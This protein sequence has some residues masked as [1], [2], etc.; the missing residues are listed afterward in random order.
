MSLV[1]TRPEPALSPIERDP[2]WR[3]VAARDAAADGQF[4]Y[5]VRTTGVYCRPTCPSRRA[6]PENVA[7]F[8][9]GLA[10]ALEGF[11]PCLRC[12]PDTQSPAQRHAAIVAAACEQI[13]KAEDL[14]DLHSLA[15]SAGLSPFHFHRVFK[16]TT[17][18]TPK[19]YGAAL[20]ARRVRKGLSSGEGS[21]TEAVY[22][23]GFNASSRF[24]ATTDAVLGMSP[25]AFRRGGADATVRFAV[26]QSS[27][28]AVLVART[29]KGVCA[30][31]LGDDPDGLVRELQ[32][33]FSKAELVGGDAQ[34]EDLVARVVGLVEQPALGLDLPLDVRGTA[35]QQRVWQALRQ[36]PPGETVSYA[37][38]AKRIGAPKAVRAV[39]T[40][41]G[42]NIL[43]VA[44]PC[45]R[46]IRQDGMGSGYRWGVERK[47]ALI[48]R[49]AQAREASQLA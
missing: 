37:E 31:L 42:S 47:R 38:I 4:V 7:F 36:I 17:G 33:R 43:A 2:R 39:G 27:L 6:K 34:F 24:Y 3:A 18:L 49:E 5:G 19:A 15:E 28:G 12:R 45:H 10:A 11:R 41:C 40:A 35:F 48:A 1:M 8:D 9:T 21:V 13:E 29:D 32:D 44:I 23:A 22:D 14:P 26:G 30:I 46:V 20:R 25:T 16:A